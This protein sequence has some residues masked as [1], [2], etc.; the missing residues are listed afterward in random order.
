MLLPI[1]NQNFNK[2]L[3]FIIAIQIFF[4]AVLSAQVKPSTKISGKVFDKSTN[5]PLEYA[6]ISIINK[7]TGKTVNGSI[8]DAKGAFGIPDVPYGTY[9]VNIEFIGYEKST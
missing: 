1:M 3:L 8:A 4:C 6:T 7:Q 5:Q 2:S 9:K